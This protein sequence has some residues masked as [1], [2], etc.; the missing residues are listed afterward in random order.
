MVYP[1]VSASW[2]LSDEPFFS[3]S[4]L[5]STLKLRGA[6]GKAGQQPNAFAAV[7]TYGPSVGSGG[8]PTVTPLNVGNIDLKPEVTREI[9]A[10]FDASSLSDRL[11]VEVTYYDKVTND[12]IFS[13]LSSP[14]TGFPGNRFINIGEFSNRGWEL[15]VAGAPI[16]GREFRV[17]VRATLATNKN[18]INVLGQDSPIPNTGVGQLVGA[19]NVSGFPMGSFFYKRIVS[20]TLTAAGRGERHDVRRRY[21]L[22]QG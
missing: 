4:S 2:V 20:A 3:Q 9:E 7:Q 15:A 13:A 11:S 19:Y 5:L 12:G 10:G 8:T 18:Q 1:K 6:W 14:S 22:R 17:N 16:N 21:R